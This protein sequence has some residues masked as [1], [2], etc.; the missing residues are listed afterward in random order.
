MN[1]SYLSVVCKVIKS[2]HLKLNF[3]K[4]LSC[5]RLGLFFYIFTRILLFYC[6]PEIFK[7]PFFRRVSI[8]QLQYLLAPSWN[9]LRQPFVFTAKRRE[10]RR[11]LRPRFHATSGFFL[12]R[13][14]VLSCFYLLIFYFETF[15][16]SLNLPFAVCRIREAFKNSLLPSL[17]L[18]LNQDNVG[19]K[20]DNSKYFS[21]FDS[22][23]SLNYFLITSSKHWPNL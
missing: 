6:T 10:G 9:F 1:L 5:Y 7:L 3:R 19:A 4:G 12:N 14:I 13:R 11:A 18:S 15:S 23:K 2:F 20:G 8:W 22:L 17:L 21:I 16:T